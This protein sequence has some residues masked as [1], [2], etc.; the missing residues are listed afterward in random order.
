MKKKTMIA[1]FVLLLLIVPMVHAATDSSSIKF[2]K[3]IKF[4]GCI[5]ARECNVGC[6]GPGGLLPV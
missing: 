3:F 6:Y 4:N 5:L 1:S 2:N